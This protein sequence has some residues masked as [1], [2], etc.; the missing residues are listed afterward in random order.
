[1]KHQSATQ[2]VLFDDVL[3]AAFMIGENLTSYFKMCLLWFFETKSVIKIQ[4]RYRSQY[5]KDPASDNAIRR[6][7]KQF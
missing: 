1:M 3:L 7:L 5:G 4:R 2:N 6:W